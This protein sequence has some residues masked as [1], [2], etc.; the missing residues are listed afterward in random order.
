MLGIRKNAGR[1]VIA[2]AHA[3]QEVASGSLDRLISA[4]VYCPQFVGRQPELTFLI[5]RRRDLAKAH[6]GI[7]LVGGDAGIGKSRLLREFLDGT[8][9][10][11]GR[12][13]VARCRPF[14]SAPYKPLTEL[15]AT[16][17][18]ATAQLIPAQTQEAQLKS[19]AD[20]F[21]V[22]AGKHAIVGII[23][24]LHWSDSG[25]LAVLA[26]LT[27]RLATS[28]MLLVVTYRANELGPE[29]PHYVAFGALLRSRSVA[30]IQLTPL[31]AQDARD[32]IDATLRTAPG[33]VPLE[34][35]RKVAHIA[36]GN[37]FF[38]EE[39]LKAVVDRDQLQQTARSLPTTIHAAILER[40]QPLAAADRAIL[41]QAA[42]IGRRFEANLLAYTLETDV[43]AVLPVLQRARALQIVEETDEHTTFRFRHAL[44]REAIYDQLLTAQRRPLHRRIALALEAQAAWNSSPDALGYHWWAA[45]DRAKTLEYGERCG[46]AAQ[47]LHGYAD[48]IECYERTLSLL[49]RSDRDAARVRAK[50][51]TSYFRSGF[52]DR[53]IDQYRQAWAFYQTATDDA[54]FIFRLARNLAAAIYNEGRRRESTA[55]LRQ[56]VDKIGRCGDRRVSER[57][58]ITFASYLVDSGEID[59]T[60]AVLRGI[61]AELIGEDAGLAIVFWETTCRV[62][63]LQGDVDGV[64][65]AADRLCAIG[66]HPAEAIAMIDGLR[67]AGISALIVGETTVA[68]R[69][70]SR[71]IDTCVA[72]NELGAA[73]GDL[74]VT[75][76]VERVLSG[77][78][79][80]ARS[81]VVRG[82]PMIGEVNVEVGSTVAR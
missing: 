70:L 47:A 75:S 72:H 68:R 35:R 77:A 45:G 28:R 1:D 10:S 5:E 46:D 50:M 79:E 67:E 43:A 64:R 80:E 51:G 16:L 69:C 41:T 81:L 37:P 30:S 63:E 56:A 49:D 11:R 7:V 24:D 34:L 3:K 76:A 18:P 52:M 39:L 29:H 57:A 73:H 25:T 36:E 20:A 62:C 14:A 54:P 60:L 42:V 26:L 58:R 33:N 19:I 55:F 21:L 17:A 15:L 4:P 22:A 13:A 66:E 71:A 27:E 31:A 32:F 12:V 2:A 61:D 9:K 6:G 82:L 38:T 59:E 23:E 65:A 40:M 48:S 44:T 53:A 8:G 78:L 74:L